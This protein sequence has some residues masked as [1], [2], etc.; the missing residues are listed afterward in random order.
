MLFG[1]LVSSVLPAACSSVS[2]GTSSKFRT[3]QTNQWLL[4]SPQAMPCRKCQVKTD[5][6]EQAPEIQKAALVYAGTG[7]FNSLCKQSKGYLLL[8]LKISEIR[9]GGTNATDIR[10][11][12]N[13]W[14]N[15]TRFS[16]WA[17]YWLDI[18]LTVRLCFFDHLAHESWCIDIMAIL[19]LLVTAWFFPQ[20]VDLRR[21]AFGSLSCY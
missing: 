20:V 18:T 5:L 21:V 10:C 12:A 16:Y 6:T 3:N 4:L 8:A 11:K 2:D 1:K 7:C 14:I 9:Y 19:Y 13:P 15:S 17:W